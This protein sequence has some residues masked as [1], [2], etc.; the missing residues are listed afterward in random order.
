MGGRLLDQVR[1]R[2]RARHY[3]RRTEEAYAYWIRRFI[4]FHDKQHPSTM[5]ADEIAR[6]LTWLA[7]E[8]RVSAST[9]NQALSAILF[10]YRDVLHVD[11]GAIEHVPRARTPERVPVVLSREEVRLVMKQLTGTSWLA[12]AL[13]YGAGLRLQ[14]CLELR[15]KDI[16]V[17]RH[18]IVVR[19]GKGQKDRR[20]MLPSSVIDRLT[21]HL[22]EV[23]RQHEHDLADGVGR[24]VMPFAF[25]ATLAVSHSRDRCPACRDAGGAGREAYQARRVSYVPAFVRDA[26]ARGRV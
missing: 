15:V 3:S 25:W 23:R 18:Q 6:F 12:V 11:V 24:A 26:L 4:V 16:D 9:Q 10:L 13:L 17:D 8:Q 14:E 7:V 19:R 22:R 2:I 21:A 20:T 1:E 5:G